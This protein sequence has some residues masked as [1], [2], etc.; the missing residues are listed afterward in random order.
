MTNASFMPDW[1]V[2][3]GATVRALM[4]RKGV[5]T[6]DLIGG[7]HASAEDI[8]SLL[9]GNYVIN[10][11]IAERLAGVVGGSSAF[12]M[13]REAQYRASIQRVEVAKNWVKLFPLAEMVGMRWMNSTTDQL[14]FVCALN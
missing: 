2:P 8:E 7:L 4:H 13:T 1:A 3:P 10:A 14:M 12:W 5:T 11:E 6:R 9:D